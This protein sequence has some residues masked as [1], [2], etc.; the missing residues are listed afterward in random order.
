[1]NIGGISDNS[2][3]RA[4]NAQGLRRPNGPDAAQLASKLLELADTDGNG[5]ISQTE[6]SSLIPSGESSSATSSDQVSSLF[7][8]LDADGDSALSSQ[9]TQVAIESLLHQMR[10]Q[11]NPALFQPPPPPPPP[12]NSDSPEEAAELLARADTDGDTS[13]DATEFSG[14]LNGASSSNSDNQAARIQSMFTDADTDSDGHL[15][16]SELEAARTQTPATSTTETSGRQAGAAPSLM[17]ALARL[18]SSSSET[19]TSTLSLSA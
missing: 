2:S 19:T 13:L 4:S 7:S 1:M 17:N 6:F 18:Y 8:Q 16:A 15:T 9:E 14:A 5:G 12:V 10:I 3:F 11:G